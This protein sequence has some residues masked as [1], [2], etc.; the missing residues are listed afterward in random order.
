[1]Y[2]CVCNGITDAEIRDCVR[3]GACCMADLQRELGVAT[4]CG[5]CASYAHQI[6]GEHQP[7]NA[8]QPA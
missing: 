1:M 3:Q 8:A 7:E 5:R 4:Q 6:V 2:I